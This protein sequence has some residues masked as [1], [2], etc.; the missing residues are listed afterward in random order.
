MA[1]SDGLSANI[2]LALIATYTSDDKIYFVRAT[3]SLEQKR[4]GITSL[5]FQYGQK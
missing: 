3:V 5:D 1:T 4:H 2:I